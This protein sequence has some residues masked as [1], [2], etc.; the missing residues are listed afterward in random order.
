MPN[1]LAKR[2]GPNQ[3]VK[4]ADKAV[5]DGTNQLI[6]GAVM[7]SMEIAKDADRNNIDSLYMCLERYIKY[8]YDNNVKLTNASVYAACGLDRQIV[9]QWATGKLRS[10]DPRY[11]EFAHYV[12]KLCGQYR[13]MLASE[14]KLNPVIAIWW[15]KNYDGF[16]DRPI[17]ISDGGDNERQLTGSEIAEKYKYLQNAAER[18]ERE[19]RQQDRDEAGVPRRGRP[20]GSKSRPKDDTGNDMK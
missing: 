16:S 11:A 1:Q 14:G 19:R 7:A 8:C 13:E 2:G 17:E 12:R 20:K 5:K 6:I 15:Q 18:F 3:L 10:G 9:M 4:A